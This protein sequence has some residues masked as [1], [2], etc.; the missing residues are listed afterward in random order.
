MTIAQLVRASLRRIRVIEENTAPS[1]EMENDGMEVLNALM[2]FYQTQRLTIPFVETTLW[3]IVSGQQD[4]SVGGAL[5]VSVSGMRIG[6]EVTS[7][8]P[9]QEYPLDFYTDQMWQSIPN[10]TLTD[11]LPQGARYKATFP[12]ATIS[13]WPIPTRTD[14]RGILYAPN[15]I[16]QFTS[17]AQTFSLPPGYLRMIRDNLALEL[18]PEYREGDPD[19]SLVRSAQIA[20]DGVKTVNVPRSDLATVGTQIYDINSDENFS[21]R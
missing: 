16:Q 18:W 21:F 5:P 20:L 7:V 1:A 3:T 8:T 15:P 10:K 9:I 17:T 6:Y 4:Y 19:P 11:T 12:T 2:D 14:L 13:L